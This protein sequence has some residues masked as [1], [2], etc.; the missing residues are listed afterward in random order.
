VSGST[1][2]TNGLTAGYDAG[3]VIHD[4]DLDLPPGRITSIVGGNGCGKSTLLR[5]LARLLKPAAGAVVL[6][7]R[8][9]DSIPTREVA[10]QLGIL[11]QS[12]TAPHGLDVEGLV[13]R[14]RYPHQGLFRQ[15]SHEDERAVGAALEATHTTHLRS[16]EV[17]SLSG[18]QRQRAWIAMALAQETEVLLLDEPTTFLDLAHQIEVLDLLAELSA[19]HGRTVAMVVHDLNQ[20]CRYSDHLIAMRDGRIHAAGPPG[21]IVDETLVRDVYGLESRLIED[22]LTG[23]PLCVP[24]APR[25]TR[26]Q[27]RNKETQ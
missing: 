24:R 22:P 15:W 9:I 11:P 8:D 18:G 19:E 2:R 17:D 12:P 16:R 13:V 25:R 10:K 3:P 1:L 4:L 26:T 23:T 21:E 20:A 14:G 7:G 27:T 6:A 5:T